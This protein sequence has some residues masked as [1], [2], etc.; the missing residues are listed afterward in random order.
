MLANLYGCPVKTLS[1]KEG[2]ALGAAILA[3]VGTGIWPDIP[4]ACRQILAELDC[5]H[6]DAQ[7][8]AA[9]EPYY[10][11][12]CELYPALADWYQRL[13]VLS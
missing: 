1:S 7:S 2:A 8:S 11:L 10:R 9:Y 4:N 6:P 13:A 3:G 5:V 12:Y